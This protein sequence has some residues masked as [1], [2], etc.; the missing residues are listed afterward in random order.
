MEGVPQRIT[1][2]HAGAL[3]STGFV[4]RESSLC[5]HPCAAEPSRAARGLSS[6]GPLMC[7]SWIDARH[8]FHTCPHCDLLQG[9]ISS[10]VQP[11]PASA[12]PWRPD[13]PVASGSAARVVAV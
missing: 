1:R 2:G 6:E 4:F 3:H 9:S 8:R 12:P 7:R 13:V 10:Q 11:V 5:S